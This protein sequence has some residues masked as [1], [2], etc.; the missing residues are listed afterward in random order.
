MPD[1]ADS[2]VALFESEESALLRFATGITGSRQSAEEIVQDAFLKL[3]SLWHEV[4]RPRPWLYRCVRNLA[5]NRQ[6]RQHREA[7]LD[8]QPEHADEAPL[9]DESLARLEACGMLRLSLAELDDLDQ[10]I[11]E[12]KYFEHK[13]YAEIAAATGLSVSHVGYKLHHLL[14]SLAARLQQAGIHNPA[15]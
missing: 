10:R 3:H 1:A 2:L 14:K 15:G 8:N 4:G 13:S 5:L 12:M 9:P 6:R 7:P 11:L